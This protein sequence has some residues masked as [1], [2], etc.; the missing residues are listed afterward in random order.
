MPK[1]IPHQSL[2]QQRLPIWARQATAEQ[3]RPLTNALA[4]AQG[5]T[6]QPPSWF[7]NAAPDL[8]EQVQDSQSRLARSQQA[9]ARAIKPLR[10]IAEFTEPLLADRL[11]TE[12]G[13]DH[14][15]RSTELIRIHHRWTHQV[16]V[17]HHER[18][19]LLEAALHN[20]ADNL[21]FSRDSALAPS[22]GIKV[23]KTTVVGQ[24][25]LGDSE[26]W[27][28]VAMASET[29]T[30]TALGLSPEDFARTCRELDLGQRYQDHLASV[31][32]PSKVAKLSKQVHRDQ[33]RLAADIAFLRHRLTGDALDI[34]KALLDDG[35]SLPCARL[36]LFD[37]PLHEVL[38]M[39]ADEAGLLVSLPGQDQALRQL[40]GM[41]SLHEQL[42]NDLL[43]AAFRQRF[44]D[45]VPRL[46]QATFL[47]RLQQ[48]LDADGNSPT[49]QNWP[50]R[51]QADLHMALL[52]V[53]GEIFDFL[54]NDH[55]ARLQAEARL[56]A[57]PTADADERE[58]KRRLALWESAGL[59]ALM[60]AGFFVPAVGTFMLAV[61][62]FQLLDE[63]Y[64][65]YEAWHAGDRHLALRHLEAVGLNLGL[66]AGL[67]VAGKVLP[68]LFNSPL[69]EGLDPITLDDGSQRLRKPDLVAYQSPVELPDT[70]RPNAKGQ[71]LHQGQ[72]FIR[73]EGS[74]YRQALD[75][76]T[77][78]WRIVHPQQDDAYRP[79]LEHNDEGAWHVD[80][81]E[82]Q[83]WSDIQLLRRLGPGLGLEAFNDAELLAALDISGVDRARL[84]EV[85][86]A[87]Q[88]TPALLADTLVRMEMARGLPELGSE[89]LESLYASQAASTMEQQLMQACPRLTTPLARRLVARLSAQ[90][91]SA[92]VTGDQLPPWLLTQAAETQG[93]LPIVRAMEGLY[94]PA[95]TSPDSERLMLDCLERLPGNAGELRIELRQSRPDGNLLASTGPEQARWRRVLIK[96][97]DGFEVYTGD[98]PVAGR[99]HRSL[100]DAL[101][102]TLPEAKRESLQADSSEA[103][104]GLLRQQAVQARGDWP[105][106]LWGL[107]RPS[108]RLG[109]RGGTPLTA[110]SVLQSPRNALFARYRRLYPRVS[111]LQISQVFANWRRRLIA[112]EAELLVR[113]RSLRDLRER[114]GAWA[115]EIPRR[116]RAARAILNAW[117][118][119]TF[120]WLIDGRALHSL[121]L[122]GL[123]LEN[124]DIADLMLSEGFTH[125]EDLNLSDNAALSHLPE[126]LLSAFPRLTRLSLGNCRFTHPPHVA[127]PSQLTWLDMESNRVTW[128]DRAQAALDRLPNLA[129]LDLSGNPLLRA[130]ALD[131]LPGLRSLMLN[132]AHLSELPSGLGQLRQALLLDLSSNTFER[133]PTG[134]EV[135]P[136]VG[137]PLAL[138][139]DWL[140]PVIREQIENYYQQHGIDLLVSDFDYQE[141]LR[142]ASAAQLRLWQKL[143]LHY[144][145]DMRAILESTQ[146]D[147]DP[148]MTREALWQ[149]IARMDNDPAFLQY[150]L[151]R[152]AI[153]LLD[154]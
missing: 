97:A 44:L 73:I 138:E 105:H 37:I 143:P 96:S 30:I 3:W 77:G 111:D 6:E 70:V 141:L 28:D 93:Q 33:L 39:D 108:P 32:A 151:E 136:D 91:R 99:Q 100:L 21:T 17:T 46:Q 38:V 154:L 145:R 101:H 62:A 59:D 117:R 85:Y 27:V 86:L 89:A 78:R 115:G 4:P 26:T 10:Q 80:Q 127:E 129:L 12:H 116:R 43:D 71:Y 49:D 24:T 133:L 5:T 146:F 131:R 107:K 55:V 20:F 110:Q 120:A 135:P 66:M 87:N 7:A 112:P 53:T 130:P 134:F 35:A 150:A 29:Y 50:R 102:E 76:T 15:L 98:R 94:Y 16:D 9:L 22:E 119:N 57:V 142:D 147:G 18:S 122:S 104:G 90:E 47:D 11:H 121:D 109:L 125:I 65:G 61:T 48:N 118:R 92:W 68:R 95:L 132:N 58:R 56:F 79:W 153:E 123:A 42:C 152:P 19:T 75:S 126:P 149:R 139:S 13:F 81:E 60:I 67:H 83:R 40:T 113:E 63:A 36:S 72:H 52:P 69:L 128:D 1:D 148:A 25:T 82:P 74:T 106:R 8:R 114:L 88:P 140:N 54:H 137:N 14:P 51:A 2:L 34:L 23:N 45:Y 31:F 84:Q 64:E 103:L 41:D 144:R 124:R